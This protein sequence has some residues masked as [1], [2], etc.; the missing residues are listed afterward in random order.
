MVTLQLKQIDL[1]PGQKVVL[2]EISW[3]QFEEI[4]KELGEHRSSRIA[5]SQGTLLIMTPLP[6]HEVVKEIIS[7]LVKIL[8]EELGL[9][10]ECFG[11][12]TFKR[13][14]LEQG[15]EPDESFYIQNYQQMI[16]KNRLDLMVD[17]PPDLAIEIEAKT[18]A[19]FDNI[20]SDERFQS[21]LASDE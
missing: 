7:D 4:I 6:E 18:D 5:Y 10:C 13:Q 15:I 11:S 16:W 1:L 20:R 9:N 21:W 17:T 19:D 8:L 12:T 14:D 2:R 3:Q